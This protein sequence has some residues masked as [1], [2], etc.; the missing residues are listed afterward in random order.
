MSVRNR[1]HFI[2]EWRE[3]V[4]MTQKQF[5]EHVGMSLSNYNYLESGRIGYTQA[6]LESI[7]SALEIR[8]SALLSVN[9]LDAVDPV[10]PQDHFFR[11][12]DELSED[13][14]ELIA[15]LTSVVLSQESNRVLRK[16]R[17]GAKKEP[18]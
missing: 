7:A 2:K 13:G 16:M 10:G 6:S 9:P 1:G 8:P 3:S 11:E 4:E 5:A 12:F 14:K 18:S 15:R 17:I